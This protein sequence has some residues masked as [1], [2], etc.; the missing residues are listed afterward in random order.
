MGD[1][2]SAGAVDIVPAFG[3]RE[4]AEQENAGEANT[5]VEKR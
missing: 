4:R 3:G 5:I 1:S 2:V